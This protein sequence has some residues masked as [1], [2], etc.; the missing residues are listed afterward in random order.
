MGLCPPLKEPYLSGHNYL[1]FLR[2]YHILV[3]YFKT[4]NTVSICLHT[5]VPWY[6][7]VHEPVSR[8]KPWLQFFIQL[9]YLIMTEVCNW[10]FIAL[11]LRNIILLYIYHTASDYVCGGELFTH[12]HQIGPFM[13]EQ[14]KIY[15]AEV[16]LALDHLHKVCQ[17]SHHGA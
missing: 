4:V 17:V 1:P 10:N 2:Y 11:M 5:K 3:V 14:A 9:T 12:L 8:I 15:A 6:P 13:E 16:T 7:T